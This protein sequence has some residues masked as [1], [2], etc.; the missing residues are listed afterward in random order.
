MN[1]LLKINK[2]SS[3]SINFIFRKIDLKKDSFLTYYKRKRE[4]EDYTPER[5]TEFS[6][7]FTSRRMM[8]KYF[9]YL[10]RPKAPPLF[11]IFTQSISKSY[12]I[13]IF[14]RISS[15]FMAFYFIQLLYIEYIILNQPKY[16]PYNYSWRVWNELDLEYQTV[17]L[18]KL[19]LCLDVVLSL[20]LIYSIGYHFTSHKV[21]LK[22]FVTIHEFLKRVNLFLKKY[23]R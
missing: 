20:G 19:F 9:G 22:Y 14:Y 11:G 1:F 16:I 18:F 3:K 5:V 10:W 21:V 13:S 8:L 17:T 2:F 4:F 23:V 15:Y 12:L 6:S 7:C